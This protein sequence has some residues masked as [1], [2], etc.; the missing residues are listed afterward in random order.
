MT[1]GY[2][3]FVTRSCAGGATV[4][5]RAQ[6]DEHRLDFS[7]RSSSAMTR[8]PAL[9]WSRCAQCARVIFCCFPEP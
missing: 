9:S 8:M 5:A 2:I 7:T 4:F 3:A 1:T 6:C